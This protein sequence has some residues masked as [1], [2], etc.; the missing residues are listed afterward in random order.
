MTRALAL[1]YLISKLGMT[2]SSTPKA[3]RNLDMG[4]FLA[5]ALLWQQ[6]PDVISASLVVVWNQ[7]SPLPEEGFC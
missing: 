6:T 3:I 1:K 5:A 2:F 7:S 4:F